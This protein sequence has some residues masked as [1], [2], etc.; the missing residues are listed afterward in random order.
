MPAKPFPHLP[1]TTS[2]THPARSPGSAPVPAITPA[3]EAED[4]V[5]THR[6]CGVCA[7]DA[8]QGK[9]GLYPFTAGSQGGHTAMGRDQGDIR[10]PQEAA[11]PPPGAA[12]PS[13]RRGTEP[14]LTAGER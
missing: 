7:E 14:P 1:G 9:L 11:Q 4:G 8:F 6:S 5:K 10:N 2:P 13:A 12:H 3:R